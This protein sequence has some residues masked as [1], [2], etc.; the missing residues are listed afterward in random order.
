LQ[1]LLPSPATRA[2]RSGHA[3]ERANISNITTVALVPV[4]TPLGDRRGVV[5]SAYLTSFGESLANAL[6]KHGESP[7]RA[8]AYSA[9]LI[10]PSARPAQAA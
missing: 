6:G 4:G 10:L 9:P 3:S 8:R 7:R 5:E 2:R 1:R